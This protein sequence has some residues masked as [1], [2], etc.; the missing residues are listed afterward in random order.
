MPG[1]I[2]GH[3]LIEVLVSSAIMTVVLAAIVSDPPIGYVVF[4]G[5]MRVVPGTWSQTVGP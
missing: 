4:T 3:T 5:A 1:R 2:S